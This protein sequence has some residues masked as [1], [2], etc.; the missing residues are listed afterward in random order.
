MHV[1]VDYF[2]RFKLEIMLIS[3]PR[4]TS[5]TV[6]LSLHHDWCPA[7]CVATQHAAVE[8]RITNADRNATAANV[9]VDEPAT[10]LG[11][12][13]GDGHWLKRLGVS[14]L[15]SFERLRSR[16]GKRVGRAFHVLTLPELDPRHHAMPI[17]P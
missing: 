16:G 10:G 15:G 9:D 13:S 4:Y 12:E 5:A 2:N 1:Y 6:P 7:E 3:L 14:P 8:A 17:T 11:N